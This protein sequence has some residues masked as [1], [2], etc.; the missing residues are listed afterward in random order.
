MTP[1]EFAQ[2]RQAGIRKWEKP[3]KIETIEEKEY[4]G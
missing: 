3:A 1:D 4:N 2:I